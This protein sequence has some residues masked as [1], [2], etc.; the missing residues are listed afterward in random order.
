MRSVVGRAVIDSA[1]TSKLHTCDI[2]VK[3]GLYS[4]V[5]FINDTY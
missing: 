2:V 4:W 5:R 3:D 1:I